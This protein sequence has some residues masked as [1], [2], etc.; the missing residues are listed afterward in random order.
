MPL[1]IPHSSIVEHNSPPKRALNQPLADHVAWHVSSQGRDVSE[2]GTGLP[3]SAAL[4]MGVHESQ[5]LLWERMVLQER[6]SPL[7]PGRHRPKLQRCP[8]LVH[9]TSGQFRSRVP[10]RLGIAA[11][12]D[13]LACQRADHSPTTPATGWLTDGFWCLPAIP[14]SP[15]LAVSS[16]L[17]LRGAQIPRALRAL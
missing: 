14:F 1:G 4:S 2:E 9:C 15:R 8:R 7:A 10:Q 11:L 6:E 12:P 13:G 16:I 17:D 5:S 3:S